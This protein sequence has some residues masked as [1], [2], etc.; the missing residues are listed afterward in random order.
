[1]RMGLPE[2]WRVGGGV[3]ADAGRKR[4]RSAGFVKVGLALGGDGG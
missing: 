1:M 3:E 4:P 2:A